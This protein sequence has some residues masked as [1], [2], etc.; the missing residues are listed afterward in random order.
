M[1]IAGL[2]R[3]IE[4]SATT[5]VP[6][7]V[8]AFLGPWLVGSVLSLESILGHVFA[9]RLPDWLL[10]AGVWALAPFWVVLDGAIGRYDSR[11]E[12]ANRSAS[13]ASMRRA[14]YGMR[15]RGLE[16]RSPNFA[17]IGF[18]EC[19]RRITVGISMLPLAPI[20]FLVAIR[21]PQRRTIADWVCGT[22]VCSSG[23]RDG[24]FCA[25]CGYNLRG[26]TEH[27]CPECGVP[28][29]PDSLRDDQSDHESR[30]NP[31]SKLE[32]GEV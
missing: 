8:W 25:K 3:R 15:S 28:F 2:V 12:A 29:D 20:S 5:A 19:V 6:V 26:L 16:F 31:A 4:A 23:K 13:V 7:L 1:R 30:G 21:D 22:I 32:C 27:R 9:D 17:D 24:S 10:L 14:T 18:G 11:P